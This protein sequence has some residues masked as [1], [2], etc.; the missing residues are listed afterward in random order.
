MAIWGAQWWKPKGRRGKWR[1]H[2]DIY[3][4]FGDPMRFPEFEGKQDDPEALREVTDRVMA[5]LDRLV[6]ELHKVHP[7]GGAVPPLKEAS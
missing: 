1:G 6:R 5:E 7:D 2:R 4:L 3:F